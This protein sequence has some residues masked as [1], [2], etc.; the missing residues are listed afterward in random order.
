M[1]RFPQPAGHKGSLRWLQ[2]LVNEHANVLDEAIGLGRIDWRSPCADD[3]F[4]E[5]RDQAFLDRLNIKLRTASLAKFWP[6]RG[7]QWD[8]LGRARSDEVILVEAKAHI[9]EIMSSGSKASPDS[10]A[11]IRKALAATASALRA[12]PGLDWA[13][14][15]YQYTNRLAHAHLLHKLNRVP[16]R[17]VFVYFIGDP[18]LDGPT[19]RREWEAAI[20]VLQEALGITGRVPSY[21]ADVFI[22]IRTPVPTAV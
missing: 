9:P 11:K 3:D 2:Q 14:R 7:P 20:N 13:E 18:D 4:A 17:L 8:A 10:L 1:G 19:T 5:Y 12:K 6:A 15:F 21:V 16:T 22:D